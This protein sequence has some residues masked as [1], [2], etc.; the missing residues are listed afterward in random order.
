MKVR[1]QYKNL[2]EKEQE[3]FEQYF[4]TKTKSFDALLSRFDEDTV[5]LDLRVEKF[6][7]HDAFE[8]EMT[9]DMPMR[10][11]QAKETSHAITKAVD[12]SKDRLL[13]QIKKALS[14][15]R[16]EQ[17]NI[18]RHSSLRKQV[19]ESVT[20]EALIQEFLEV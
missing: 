14:E 16:D 10:K 7:K 11:L 8:V 6:D 5:N 1:Y 2:S 9:L 19:S 15:V 4:S 12:L 20:E 3:I 13:I 17:I 18:R